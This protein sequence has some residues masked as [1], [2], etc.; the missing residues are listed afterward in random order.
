MEKSLKIAIK[1]KPYV[2]SMQQDREPKKTIILFQKQSLK[3]TQKD[4][5]LNIQLLYLRNEKLVLTVLLDMMQR[6]LSKKVTS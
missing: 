6:E 4:D 2:I 1:I 5:I 3:K